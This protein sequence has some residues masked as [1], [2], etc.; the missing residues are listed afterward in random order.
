MCQCQDAAQLPPL[1]GELGG[2]LSESQRQ[3]IAIARALVVWDSLILVP[4]EPTAALDIKSWH[5]VIAALGR[6]MRGWTVVTVAHR[7][8]ALA[9][10]DRIIVIKDAGWPREGSHGERSARDGIFAEL[11]R[12]QPG[13]GRV[14]QPPEMD[15]GVPV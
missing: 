10:A 14:D 5:R 1:V 8:T 4:D 9:D 15:F 11:H 13:G 12:L 2:T 6:L 7:L 3:R